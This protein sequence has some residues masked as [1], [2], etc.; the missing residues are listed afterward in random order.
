M[1]QL[2]SKLVGREVDVV[3]AGASSLRGECIK[4]ADG[5][6]HLKD[7]NGETCYIAIDKIVVVWEKKEK[8]RLPGFVSKG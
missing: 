6:L 7:E 8:G 5:A 4:V 3:C 1:E 2:L